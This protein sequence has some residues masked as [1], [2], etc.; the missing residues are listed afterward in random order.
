MMS[1]PQRSGK[2]DFVDLFYQLKW[3]A[4]QIV[5]IFTMAVAPKW[6]QNCLPGIN[7][8]EVAQ[9]YQFFCILQNKI[10]PLRP[11]F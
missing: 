5:I 9:F 11:H 1:E 4:Q 2:K 3:L 7:S 10:L 8:V 6:E